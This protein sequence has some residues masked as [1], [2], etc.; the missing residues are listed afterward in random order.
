MYVNLC[1]M[2]YCCGCLSE[3]SEYILLKHSIR[4]YPLSMDQNVDYFHSAVSAANVML[5]KAY[6][7][8]SII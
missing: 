1:P 7:Y 6:K 5:L 2:F 4:A 3:F 8:I